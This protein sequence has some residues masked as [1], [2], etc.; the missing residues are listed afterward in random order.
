MHILHCFSVV[1]DELLHRQA[2]LSPMTR[3]VNSSVSVS[4][5]SSG[6]V[7][8]SI[9]AGITYSNIKMPTLVILL[10]TM[11]HPAHAH[12]IVAYVFTIIVMVMV[13]VVIVV[14]AHASKF[15]E[16]Y[17]IYSPVLCIYIILR[18]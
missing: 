7:L 17:F 4:T 18:S 16:L 13:M 6:S 8:S 12:I 2:R 5:I 1:A 11:P 14:V 3:Y 9:H 10:N 15:G